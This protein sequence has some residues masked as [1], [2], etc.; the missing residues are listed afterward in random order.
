MKIL[1][2]GGKLNDDLEDNELVVMWWALRRYII[3]R[4]GDEKITRSML[5]S[6]ENESDLNAGGES[7]SEMATCDLQV[8]DTGHEAQL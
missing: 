7:D 8:A 5:S 6:R 4:G 3:S 2:D 1:S